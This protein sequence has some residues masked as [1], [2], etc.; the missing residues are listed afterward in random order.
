MTRTQITGWG[1]FFLLVLISSAG[2]LSFENKMFEVDVSANQPIIT[3][4][5][6][7]RFD[8]V[9]E[10]QSFS[11]I[12][13]Q[14]GSSVSLWQAYNNEIA[15]Q[16]GSSNRNI[17]NATFTYNQ[18]TNTLELR[19]ELEESLTQKIQ[20]ET[21]VELW[22]M[23]GLFRNFEQ[24]SN[25][26]I[27]KN[28]TIRLILKPGAEPVGEWTKLATTNRNIVTFTEISSNNLE[29]QY[30]IPKPIA[31]TFSADFL[32]TLIQE[33]WFQGLIIVFIILGGIAYWKRKE[34]IRKMENYVIEHSE[35]SA[36]DNPEEDEL[37][38]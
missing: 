18:S 2:A 28:T 27:P 21:R 15:P 9:A 8:N 25:I 24:G 26:V 38:E 1:A 17:V 30:K 35:F 22:S 20:D 16:F 19:Y 14:N 23:S 36:T 33:S 37:E 6:I 5:F 4:Q 12:V 31:P 32:Q 3:E 34:I 7:L 13:A 10:R 11:D 29:V